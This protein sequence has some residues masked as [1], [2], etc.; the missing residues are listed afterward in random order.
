MKKAILVALAFAAA[1][2]C[3]SYTWRSQVPEDMRTVYVPT[4]RNETEVVEL[5][6]LATGQTLREFQRE[7]TIRIASSDDAALE[8][9]V[10]LKS[11]PVGM[12]NFKR[13]QSMRAYE[14]RMTLHAEMSLVDRRNGRVLVDNKSYHAETTFFSDTDI[15]TS[16]RDASGRL[17]EDLARQIVDDVVGYRW[18]KPG[19]GAGN[20]KE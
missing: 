6:A 3:S 11:A 18:K 15:V 16:R 19:E 4:F 12:L 1:A 10:V 2:G 17:A 8:V 9:Q 14:H 13:S 5:G 7:G 20:D